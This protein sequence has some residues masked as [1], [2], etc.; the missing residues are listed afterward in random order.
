MASPLSG[1]TSD[2]IGVSYDVALG[3]D[4]GSTIKM[5]GY[6]LQPGTK[7][8]EATDIQDEQH[9][10]QIS[11]NATDRFTRYPKISQGDW[12]GGER[13]AFFDD[14]KKYFSTDGSINATV[15]GQ[16]QLLANRTTVTFTDS[17]GGGRTHAPIASEGSFVYVGHQNDAT[18]NLMTGSGNDVTGTFTARVV[19]DGSRILDLLGDAVYNQTGV[20]AAL[21]NGGGATN[22]ILQ[23]NSTGGTVAQMTNDAVMGVAVPAMC[24]LNANLF[25]ATAGNI[26]YV[27]FATP[28]GNV[29]GN[30]YFAI[31]ATEG[32]CT[33]LFSTATQ[34]IFTTENGGTAVGIGNQ[35]VIWSADGVNTPTRLGIIPGR[36]RGGGQVN[37]IV[38]LVVFL[39]ANFQ[40]FGPNSAQ[41]GGAVIYQ[42][43]GTVISVFDDLRSLDPA[44]QNGVQASA[45]AA[46]SCVGDGRFMFVS[47]PGLPVRA[48]DMN[49]QGN[50]VFQYSP[51]PSAIGTTQV[52][53]RLGNILNLGGTAASPISVAFDS[54]LLTTVL[55][56]VQ[57]FSA[58]NSG[59]I[60]LSWMDFG[61]P[62]TVKS[63]RKVEVELAAAVP[64]GGSVT[65]GFS[66]DDQTGVTPI[67]LATNS[68][69]NLVGYF[70]YPTKAYRVQ[71]QATLTS[72]STVTLPT[73]PV[74][75]SISVKATLGRSWKCTV[76][77]ARNQRLRNQYS[78]GDDQ[79]GL[80][81]QDKLANITNAY[82]LRAGT[83]TMFIPSPTQPSG[84]EQVQ[85]SLEDYT[86]TAHAEPG[87]YNTEYGSLDME[88]TVDLTLVESL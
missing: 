50:P 58:N 19:G 23:I 35:T 72:G 12:S 44:F 2:T 73:S 14:P 78:A 11:S 45:G 34:L 46:C 10:V 87:P 41:P 77:C 79:Q 67:T 37:G 31:P 17:G 21:T 5:V 76:A 51:T 84:V 48:Y 53:S 43:D 28:S 74:V 20:Y 1:V 66:V 24:S 71:L 6:V 40:P 39:G 69:G 59:T 29:A 8:T 15:P 62:G 30:A 33:S 86:W 18:H 49:T 36:V 9:L 64:A 57:V 3:Y 81:A 75:R 83:V 22:G 13:Q 80:R 25:Y 16:L 60:T 52:A 85:A 55:S 47:V 42:V 54:T 38:Y 61:A 82:Q 7:W 68:Q 70:P 26:R 56:Q 63:F 88:G 65:L 4:T 32:V 27:P